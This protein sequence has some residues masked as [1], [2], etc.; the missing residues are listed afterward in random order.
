MLTRVRLLGYFMPAMAS[1]DGGEISNL[2]T[3]VMKGNDVCENA[4]KE[5]HM[6]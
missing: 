6:W 3:G 2:Y 5:E 1:L 4:R